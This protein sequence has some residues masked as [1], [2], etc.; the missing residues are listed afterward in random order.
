MTELQKHLLALV[1]KFL[2]AQKNEGAGAVQ[3]GKVGGD[4]TSN[5]TIVTVVGTPAN[6]PGSLT[7]AEQ[8]EVLG[9]IR[10]VRNS[11]TVFLF[12]ER[13]FGTRMVIDLQPSQLLR[14]RRY[15]EAI[16]NRTRKE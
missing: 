4:V 14:V 12:M 9:L 3:V 5:V 1:S 7:T 2:P 8:R 15:A 16:L 10:R 13:Q 11:E 6:T